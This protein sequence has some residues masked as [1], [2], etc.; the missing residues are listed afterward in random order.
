MQICPISM[1]LFNQTFIPEFFPEH[2]GILFQLLWCSNF[3]GQI[4]NKHAMYTF[5]DQSVGNLIHS[6]ILIYSCS[7]QTCLSAG[8]VL[9]FPELSYACLTH[10]KSNICGQKCDKVLESGRLLFT[11]S[12]TSFSRD[13]SQVLNYINNA[14]AI[15]EYTVYYSCG[16][17]SLPNTYIPWFEHIC[18]NHL[19]ICSDMFKW[20]L[21]P[22][23]E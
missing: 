5:G 19:N 1:Y 14:I 4:L 17:C 12:H 21:C 13:V 9:F 6:L 22:N 15:I 11:N 16:T 10:S 8:L 20:L 18:S 7:R 2:I 23:T 3:G